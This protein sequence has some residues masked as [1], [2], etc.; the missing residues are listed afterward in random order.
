MGKNRVFEVGDIE[1]TVITSEGK[2]VKAKKGEYIVFDEYGKNP[3][4]ISRETYNKHREDVENGIY[5][6]STS[7]IF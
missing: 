1:V 5:P 7:A 6:I 4:I 3:L 2:R